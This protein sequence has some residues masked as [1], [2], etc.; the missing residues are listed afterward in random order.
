METQNK[1]RIIEITTRGGPQPDTP[2]PK[3]IQGEKRR[4]RRN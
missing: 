1:K 2:I 4:E 3:E